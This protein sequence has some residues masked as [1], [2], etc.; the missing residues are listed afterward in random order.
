MIRRELVPLV[1]KLCG[2]LGDGAWL[3]L[4]GLLESDRDEIEATLARRGFRVDAERTRRDGDERWIA[5]RARR[6]TESTPH[7]RVDP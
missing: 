6:L 5:L 7:A 3:W 4:S 2:K 1:P